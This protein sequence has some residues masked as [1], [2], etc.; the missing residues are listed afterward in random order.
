MLGTHQGILVHHL[1]PYEIWP[2]RYWMHVFRVLTQPLDP[3]RSPNAYSFDE[4]ELRVGPNPFHFPRITGASELGAL[5]A[6]AH[7]EKAGAFVQT[8][9]DDWYL[10]VAREQSKPGAGYFAEKQLERPNGSQ[11][12]LWE[13][14]PRARELFLVRDFR[15]VAASAV[16][17]SQKRGH[18]VMGWSRG[19]DAVA[20][21]RSD[22]RASV[23]EFLRAWQDR[24]QRS[25]LVRYED[26]I[27]RP[28]TA[29]TGVLDYLGL[30][31]SD[32]TIERLVRQGHGTDREREVHLTSPDAAT[33]IGRW[34]KEQDAALLRAFEEAFEDLL[35]QFGYTA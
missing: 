6:K 11:P 10:T 27:E 23:Q 18:P 34:R 12:I 31:R 8:A 16:S 4:D 14:Y 15:D 25:H 26:L 2:A 28:H 32:E 5:L 35:P 1:Y 20:Y 7:V 13:L 19:N 21:V 29:L 33:S 30:D 9:V 24:G 17:F 3:L 22:L